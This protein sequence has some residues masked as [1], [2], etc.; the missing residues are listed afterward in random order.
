MYMRTGINGGL[1][2]YRGFGAVEPTSVSDLPPVT[3]RNSL[4]TVY[5][6]PPSNGRSFSSDSL[7]RPGVSVDDF[8]ATFGDAEKNGWYVRG[9][10]WKFWKN[11]Q[12][13]GTFFNP[14]DPLNGFGTPPT[15]GY[16]DDYPNVLNATC[17]AP[18]NQGLSWNTA[19]GNQILYQ[20]LVL[21]E[22]PCLGHAFDPNAPKTYAECD[23]HL[24]TDI[25]YTQPIWTDP[26]TG[27]RMIGT[28]V[29]PA[30]PLPKQTSGVAVGWL[31][32]EVGKAAV[33]AGLSP[34]QVIAARQAV[35]NDP[36]FGFKVEREFDAVN[37][38]VFTT[39]I[40]LNYG[41]LQ[42]YVQ[43]AVD[44]GRGSVSAAFVAPIIEQPTGPYGSARPV[45]PPAVLPASPVQQQY[46]ANSTPYIP[47]V[48]QQYNPSATPSVQNA[49]KIAATSPYVASAYPSSG[50]AP[51]ISS[52][53]I[54]A[55]SSGVLDSAMAW[56]SANPLIAAGGALALFFMFG[57]GR[58]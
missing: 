58:R 12:G 47:P 43:P 23:R 55:S 28:K 37:P 32:N 42:K 10:G 30:K 53:S 18:E 44:A 11:S 38:Q 17:T 41:V 1:A 45:P 50:A 8:F 46:V 26:A 40:D 3:N 20:A 4:S 39:G 25:D 27:N 48:V 19:V 34:G 6:V 54:A 31:A 29:I 35:T 33:A 51:L 15:T 2:G 7:F 16:N 57:R 9:R 21:G 52:S 13:C 56:V 14:A 49:A 36:N 24:T 5:Y 22:D